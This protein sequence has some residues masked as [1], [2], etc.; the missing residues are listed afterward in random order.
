MERKKIFSDAK[1]VVVKIG[2]NVLTKKDGSLDEGYVAQVAGQVAELKKN[3]RSVII[4]SSGAIGSG[5]TWTIVGDQL[6]LSFDI[7]G[8]PLRDSIGLHWAEQCGNDVIEG[9]AAVPEANAL[10]LLGSG[11]VGLVGFGRRFKK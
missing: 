5:G 3:G 9:V 10:L 8:I 1:K 6:I 11:L 4:V 2:T 7:G